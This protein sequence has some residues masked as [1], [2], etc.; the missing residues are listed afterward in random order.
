LLKRGAWAAASRARASCT[1]R[2]QALRD[3]AVAGKQSVKEC[4]CVRSFYAAAEVCNQKK[5]VV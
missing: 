4:V 1:V 5:H 3:A 2:A